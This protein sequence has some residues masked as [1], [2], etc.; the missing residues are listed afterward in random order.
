M[1]KSK[2]ELETELKTLKAKHGRVYTI[3]STPDEDKPEETITIFL[4]KSDRMAADLVRREVQKSVSKGIEAGLRNL[5]IGGDALDLIVK[6]DDAL[7]SCE[8][9]LVELMNKQEA[10][11]KKN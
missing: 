9:P 1:K 8:G 2:E 4:R 11:L 5:Y 7:L 10:V 3:T 6:N